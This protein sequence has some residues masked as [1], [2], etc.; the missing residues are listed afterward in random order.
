MSKK[1][2]NILERIDALVES[3]ALA[4]DET[5]IDDYASHKGMNR[6]D[7]Y[8]LFRRLENQG[9][10]ENTGRKVIRNGQRVAVWRVK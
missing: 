10:V 7:A 9:K 8:N 5:T 1:L 3:D 2:T 6:R 4:Q